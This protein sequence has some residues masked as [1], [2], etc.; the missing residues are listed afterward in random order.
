LPP[1]EAGA[2]H[3]ITH[4][5]NAYDQGNTVVADLLAYDDDGY[6][7]ATVANLLVDGDHPGSTHPLRFIIDLDTKIVTNRSILPENPTTI[8]FSQYNRVFEGRYNK[9]GYAVNHGYRVPSQI[10]KIDMDTPSGANNKYFTPK[11][12]SISLGE[13]YYVPRPDAIDE[14][15]GVI[16][17]RGLDMSNNRTRVYVVDA[18]T[19]TQVGEILSPYYTPFGLHERFYTKKKCW[20]LK[21][22]MELGR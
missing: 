3:F 22:V 19:M 5:F 6:D 12:D 9:F 2:P 14:D 15:D 11:T 18:K 1:I 21:L 10:I 20:A 13:P 4:T 8:E 7:H 17:T 16:V